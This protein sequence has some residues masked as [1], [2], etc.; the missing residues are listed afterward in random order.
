MID[1]LEHFKWA[2]VGAGAGYGIHYA[3]GQMFYNRDLSLALITERRMATR[4]IH[5]AEAAKLTA[6]L[7]S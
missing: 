1:P 5:E 4:A 3:R 6:I 7:S 2:I